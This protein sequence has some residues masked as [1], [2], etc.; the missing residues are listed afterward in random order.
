ML[1]RVNYYTCKKKLVQGKS[2][3]SSAIGKFDDMPG[4]KNKMIESTNEA[5]SLPDACAV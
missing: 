1:N 2:F 3:V 5:K 4:S